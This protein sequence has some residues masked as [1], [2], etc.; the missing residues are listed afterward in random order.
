MTHSKAIALVH[1]YLYRTKKLK[2]DLLW[3]DEWFQTRSCQKWAVNELL[4]YL[5]KFPLKDPIKATEEFVFK[6]DD[7]A[8]RQGDTYMFSIAY[9]TSMD[10]LDMLL[11]NKIKEGYQNG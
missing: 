7:L 11:L 5:K 10:V 9:D 8:C 3:N 4:L 1:Q 2:M 6:M